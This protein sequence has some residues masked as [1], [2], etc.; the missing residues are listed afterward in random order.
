MDVQ[1]PGQLPW[2][3]TTAMVQGDAVVGAVVVG[4][5]AREA[6]PGTNHLAIATTRSRG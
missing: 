4:E 1:G 6:G 5:E 2:A 3:A